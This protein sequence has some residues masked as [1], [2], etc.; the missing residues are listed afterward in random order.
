[1]SSMAGQEKCLMKFSPKGTIL[2]ALDGLEVAT[3]DSVTE[4]AHVD[5]TKNFRE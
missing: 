4:C 3:V 2:Q 1:M 5:A